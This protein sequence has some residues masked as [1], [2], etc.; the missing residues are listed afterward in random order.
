MEGKTRKR[1][2]EGDEGKNK[3]KRNMKKCIKDE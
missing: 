3:I 1:N 2:K